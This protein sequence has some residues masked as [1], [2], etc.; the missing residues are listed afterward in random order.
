MSTVPKKNDNLFA[1]AVFDVPVDSEDFKNFK[2]YVL[3]GSCKKCG[4]GPYSLV[5]NS[6]TQNAN[7]PGK[8][9]FSTVCISCGNRAVHFVKNI[10]LIKDTGST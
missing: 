3:E 9:I 10:T 6:F 8:D 2:F 1:R 7:D 4:V 5:W